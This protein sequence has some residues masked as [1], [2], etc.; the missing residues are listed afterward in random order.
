MQATLFIYLWT[1]IR[2][3]A[4][5]DETSRFHGDGGSSWSYITPKNTLKS[6]I[7]HPVKRGCNTQS[8][9]PNFSGQ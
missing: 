4:P 1:C 8:I 6:K 2:G 5:W 9:F 7:S 3:S